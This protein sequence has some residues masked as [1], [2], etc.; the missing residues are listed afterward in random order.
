MYDIVW[1]IGRW[2]AVWKNSGYSSNFGTKSFPK[3]G[4]SSKGAI[5]ILA[6]PRRVGGRFSPS[7]KKGRTGWGFPKLG[8]TSISYWDWCYTKELTTF[9]YIY[10]TTPISCWMWG[11]FVVMIHAVILPFFRAEKQ[12]LILECMPN[13]VIRM[14]ILTKSFSNANRYYDGLKG[15]VNS[16]TRNVG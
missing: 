10:R 13:L 8:W 2:K 15:F 3:G 9:R 7:I 1:R 14:G 16:K 6:L 11:K 4:G 5:K 12:E